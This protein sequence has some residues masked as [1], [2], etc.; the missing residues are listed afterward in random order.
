MRKQTSKHTLCAWLIGAALTT[1]LMLALHR[2]GALRYENSDEMLMVKAFMGFEG[3]V[4][5]DYTLYTH[6]LAA[7]ALRLLA[8]LRADVP[9]FSVCQLALLWLS[10]V[11]IGKSLLQL[12]WRSG[13][14]A[15]PGLA[16]AAL[17]AIVFEAFAMC[18]I[19]YTTTAALAGAASVAQWMSLNFDRRGARI[20]GMLLCLLLL[21]CGYCLRVTAVLPSAAFLGLAAALRFVENKR[22]RIPV[23]VFAL[24]ALCLFGALTGIRS[25]EIQRRGLADE[26]AWQ[27]ARINLMDYTDFQTNLQPAL[28]AD[29]GLSEE[30]IALVQQWYFMDGNITTEAL[31]AM[32]NAYTPTESPWTQLLSFLHTYSRQA[33]ALLLVLALGLLDVCS[34]PRW[35][36]WAAALALLGTAAQ[37]ILLSL[38]G[39]VI[40]RAVDSVLMPC[41][42]LL[43]ALFV[44]RGK[45]GVF[46]AR[47]LIAGALASICIVLAGVHGWQTF[48][49]LRKTPDSVSQQRED[50]L[51]AYALAHPEQLIVRSCDLLRDTRLWPDVSA[52]IPGNLMIW[53]DWICHTPSW[54]AQLSR[55]GF[56]AQTFSAEDWLSDSILFAAMEEADAQPLLRHLENALACRIS[57]SEA[58]Q[59]GTV[60]LYRF[61]RAE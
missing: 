23:L 26:V 45:M 25:A 42:A 56:D 31:Q 32:A 33:L 54:D 2:L 18:R 8:S 29:T 6:T 10:G 48:S 15:L 19:T 7:Y 22:Q 1:L 39:R 38:Q 53:G 51:E 35:G 5:A 27:E 44:R 3:G 28:D 49:Q 41:G 37:M 14:G 11:V 50:E 40:P 60:R 20:G 17:C 36:A 16:A 24:A 43:C 59:S 61:A 52:G 47:Q 57:L 55:F 21:V 46:P 34:Q 58:A 4:P 9:W 13:R 12:S 30:E